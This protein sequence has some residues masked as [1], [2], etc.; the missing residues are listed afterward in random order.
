MHY[1][2]KLPWRSD[3]CDFYSHFISQSETPGNSGGQGKEVLLSAQEE[4]LVT[5]TSDCHTAPVLRH[6]LPGPV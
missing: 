6:C 2:L 1:F 4:N 5:N 3:P